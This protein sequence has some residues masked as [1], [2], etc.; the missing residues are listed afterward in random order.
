MMSDNEGPLARAGVDP[1]PTLKPTAAASKAGADLK[2]VRRQK[3]AHTTASFFNRTSK[4]GSGRS[5]ATID[6][7]ELSTNGGAG[8][9]SAP[10]LPTH[11]A[12]QPQPCEAERQHR[13]GR[14]LGDGCRKGRTNPG[15]K[16][17]V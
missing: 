2:A 17:S 12:C 8:P 16:T 10:R 13:P 6:E 5:R 14:R 7:D 4:P 11:P 3:L 15:L 9:A 1:R